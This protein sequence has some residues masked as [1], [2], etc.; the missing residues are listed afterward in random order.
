[1]K[2]VIVGCELQIW[3]PFSLLSLVG[4]KSVLLL[5]GQKVKDG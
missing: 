3:V 5:K 2:G 4:L 1:M